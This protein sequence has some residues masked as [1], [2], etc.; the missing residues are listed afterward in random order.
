MSILAE[1]EAIEAEQGAASP[2]NDNEPQAEQSSAPDEA[3]APAN[4]NSAE[5]QQPDNDN[6]KDQ[7]QA[8][9]EGQ[10]LLSRLPSDAAEQRKLLGELAK[11]LGLHV[12]EARV[13]PAERAKWREEKRQEKAALQARIAEFERVQ[14]EFGERRARHDKALSA[15]ESG[16][17]D[18]A[19]R[20]LFGAGLE[21]A[22]KRFV[23]GMKGRDP[24]LEREKAWLKAERE[25]IETERKAADKARAEQ[26]RLEQRTAY[27]R[28]VGRFLSEQSDPTI[29]AFASDPRMLEQ[30]VAVQER[31]YDP[32]DGSVMSPVE[33]AQVVASE[34]RRAYEALHKVF[35]VPATSTPESAPKAEAPRDGSAPAKRRVPSVSNKRAN[36]AN[37][38]ADWRRMALQ[39]LEAAAAA[40]RAAGR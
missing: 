14:G 19:L 35:G 1:F 24:E 36:G 28:D 21:E 3:T 9:E 38:E 16:D 7:D 40:D 4:D 20:E 32:E 29:K 6:G 30:I 33:A 12:A 39:E 26:T 13:E 27:V 10:G 23:E 18:G 2:A 5:A 25:K 34:A 17:P 8:D 31:T 11:Q 15:W 22:N 37:A